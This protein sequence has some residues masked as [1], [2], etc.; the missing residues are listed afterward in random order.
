MLQLAIRVVT[1]LE[2]LIGQVLGIDT[3]TFSLVQLQKLND[4]QPEVNR[5]RI[6]AKELILLVD[7]LRALVDWLLGPFSSEAEARITFNTFHMNT[8]ESV[9]QMRRCISL[10]AD[11]LGKL[12]MKVWM[13][14]CRLLALECKENLLGI[15][16]VASKYRMTNKPPP[17]G[18]SP[19]V[20][21]ILK[22]L[23]YRLLRTTSINM[24]IARRDFVAEYPSLIP[25]TAS[26]WLP[27]V[28]ASVTDFFLQQVQGIM[29]T[30]RQMDTALQRRS[31]LRQSTQTTP[32]GTGVISDSDKIT[33]QLLLDAKAYGL[34]VL[35]LGA[36]PT[37]SYE[38]LLTELSDAERYLV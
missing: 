30:V 18:P 19:Y 7:D 33:L 24:M 32:A 29:E 28:T 13:E 16:G 23:R 12:R 22:P 14:T 36:E 20:E 6:V 9:L 10:Q 4:A 27:G 11:K 17:S 26:A 8:T 34:E 3:P 25:E 31:K 21:L 38:A 35:K 1:R 15:K 37:A 2:C 5:P